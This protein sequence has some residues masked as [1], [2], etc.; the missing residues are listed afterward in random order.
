VVTITGVMHVPH[1]VGPFPVVIL[2]HGYIPPSRYWSGADTWRA[3]DYLA[4]HG[5]LTIAPDVH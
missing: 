2:N 1:G 3:A 5:Y 4:R